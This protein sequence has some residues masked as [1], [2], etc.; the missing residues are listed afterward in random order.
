[1]SVPETGLNN[2]AAGPTEITTR[3]GANPEAVGLVGIPVASAPGFPEQTGD[4]QYH[5][6]REGPGTNIHV[7][8]W[9]R[10]LSTGAEKKFTRVPAFV[11]NP[12]KADYGMD[13]EYT[14]MSL[15]QVNWSMRQAAYYQALDEADLTRKRKQMEDRSIFE[16]FPK[17]IPEFI[18]DFRYVGWIYGERYETEYA[19]YIVSP[20]N[21]L[22]NICAKGEIHDVVNYWE[23]LNVKIG[24]NVGFRVVKKMLGAGP[25]KNWDG[26]VTGQSRMSRNTPVIQIEPWHDN[27]TGALP[28]SG[29]F[30]DSARTVR[31]Q[32]GRTIMLNLYE[33]ARTI[34]VGHVQRTRR[35]AKGDAVKEALVSQ[36][37]VETML[38]TYQTLDLI[39]MPQTSSYVV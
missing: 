14:V 3:G 4:G 1:M 5:V 16:G 33:P 19:S 11:Y 7:K 15:D 34:L 18:R 10:P 37:G 27:E 26:T 38:R 39:L 32:N 23:G 25:D 8:L 28:L 2:L 20:E 24:D 22:F 9:A 21:S 6:S 36:G 12:K 17:T 13:N 29:D 35:V 31:Q 30:V